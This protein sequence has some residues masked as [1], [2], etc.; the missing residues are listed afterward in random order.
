VLYHHSCPQRSNLMSGE[1]R[2]WLAAQ[3]LPA[4][5]REQITIVLSMIDALDRQL[6]PLDKGAARVSATAV[7]L[8]GVDG[9]VRGG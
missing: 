8:Q 7:W 2:S 6:G 9:S 1:G 3:P 4:A 5:A